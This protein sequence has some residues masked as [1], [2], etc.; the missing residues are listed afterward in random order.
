MFFMFF[1]KS[2]FLTSMVAMITSLGNYRSDG[3][4]FSAAAN[5]CG[6]YLGG[7][8]YVCVRAN[9]SVTTGDSGLFTI[10]GL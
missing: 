8:C 1:C 6:V 10:G 4:S 5:C 3:G 2:M 9:I 7:V